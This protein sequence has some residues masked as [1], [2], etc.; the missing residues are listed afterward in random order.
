MEKFC[1]DMENIPVGVI[2][3]LFQ[4]ISQKLPAFTDWE[5]QKHH[6]LL[7]S[8]PDVCNTMTE[9]RE[10]VRQYGK[11]PSVRPNRLLSILTCPAESYL[12]SRSNSKFDRNDFD[13]LSNKF[14]SRLV[15]RA[16]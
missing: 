16:N 4:A 10:H 6:H 12:R 3:G 14:I 2:V 8:N 15:V 11:R 1:N 13:C 9:V 7:F 5:T